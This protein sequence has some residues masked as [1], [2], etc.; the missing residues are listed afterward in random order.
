MHKFT[1]PPKWVNELVM[2]L[3]V[4]LFSQLKQWALVYLESLMWNLLG[5]LSGIIRYM[6]WFSDSPTY[7]SQLETE[8]HFPADKENL[9]WIF[10]ISW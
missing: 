6:V 7:R 4:E 1:P 2:N 5:S 10:F 8:I 9:Q 3:D